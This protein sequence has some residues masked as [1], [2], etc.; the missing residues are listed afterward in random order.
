MHKTWV[1]N[2]TIKS[3]YYIKIMHKIQ[4]TVE[5]KLVEEHKLCIK[6]RYKD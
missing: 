1:K 5:A 2:F 3:Y 4:E 6:L